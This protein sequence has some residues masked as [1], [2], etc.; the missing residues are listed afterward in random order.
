M[1]GWAGAGSLLT[2][3]AALVLV[4]LALHD[5]ESRWESYTKSA[6]N[7]TRPLTSLAKVL[8][9]TALILAALTLLA[10]LVGSHWW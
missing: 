8:A 6:L 7:V 2:A 10:Y 4:A 5:L 9:L 1:A 3:A